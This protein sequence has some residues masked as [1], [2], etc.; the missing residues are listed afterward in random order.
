M[1]LSHLIEQHRRFSSQGLHSAFGDGYLMANN[2][3]YRGV[4]RAAQSADYSFT[5]ERNESY[6]A[7]PLL[8]LENLLTHR[9]L[10]YVKNMIAFDSMTAVQMEL[11][12]WSDIDGNLKKN[13]VFHEAAH[14]V[15]RKIGGELLPA[16]SLP[17]DL[18]TQ[19]LFALRM[20]VEESC[21]NTSE[22]FGIVDVG[23]QVH[24]IFFQMNSY[25]ENFDF[26]THLKNAIVEHGEAQVF[27]FMFLSY[28][29]A[30]MLR[31]RLS[32]RDVPGMLEFSGIAKTEAK[33]LKQL[34]TLSHV[35]F[36]LSERFRVQTTGFH[37]RLAGISSPPQKL[38][39]FDFLRLIEPYREFTYRWTDTL[40]QAAV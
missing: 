26:R 7:L 5:C 28:V 18:P 21:A 11:L 12:E 24:R 23:D 36:Q 34:R 31:E 39:D 27:R 29:Q 25:M 2:R 30:N 3:Y 40:G 15:A 32:E 17:K 10:P 19:Q 14:A 37:L 38:F 6:E 20:I 8:Q 1:K 22:L 33:H 13:F 35:A 4:R 16:V 9:Q